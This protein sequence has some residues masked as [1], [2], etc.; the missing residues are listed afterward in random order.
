[1]S[2]LD[3]TDLKIDCAADGEEAVEMYK[4]APDKYSLIFMDMQMPN[5]DGLQA[6][7][8][9]RESGLPTA[10]TIPIVA[11]TAN[12]FKEDIENCN[13]A[14]M[15]DHIGKP[16]DIADVMKKLSFYLPGR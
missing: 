1:V 14:G 16:I 8:L 11:M 6:T 13:K 4:A 10:K 15:N 7:Q 2:L 3:G 12:V 5:I 9:I